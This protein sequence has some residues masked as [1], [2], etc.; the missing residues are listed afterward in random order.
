MRIRRSSIVFGA[1]GIVLIAAAA[2]VRFAI[3]PVA[4]RLPASTDLVIHYAGKATLLNP[5]A[6]ASGDTAKVLQSGVP[7]TLDRRT[8]VLST[9]GNTA[10]VSDA[11][12]VHAGSTTL[13][14]THV[15]AVNRSNLEATRPPNGQ[16]VEPASGLTV[17]FPIGPKANNSY[18]YYDATTERTVPVAYKGS[19]SS[20]G[21]GTH[22]Y[23]ITAAGPVKDKNLLSTLPAS[24]PKKT[25]ASLAPLLPANLRAAL[26]P[27]LSTLPDPVPLTYTASTAI[28]AQADKTTGIAINES[29]NETVTVQVAVGGRTVSLVPVLAINASVT[30]DSIHYLAGKA[31]S[32]ARLLFL[33]KTLAPLVLLILGLVA[34]VVAI[35]RRKPATP[36]DP[37]SAQQTGANAATG[38]ADRSQEVG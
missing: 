24:L 34:V 22:D 4:T 14:N 1:V 12:T 26:T 15:Y 33:V 30:P 5:A 36:E 21:R 28:T 6:L 8:R 2:V 32:A 23:A 31:K 16:K 37:G 17:T 19:S 27:A 18:R 29:I 13:P 9:H 35:L 3:V 20:G 25:L 10:I 7:I 11:I 38:P